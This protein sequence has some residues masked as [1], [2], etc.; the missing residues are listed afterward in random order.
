M[1]ASTKTQPPSSLDHIME[2]YYTFV[3][4]ANP[5]FDEIAMMAMLVNLR[6]DNHDNRAIFDEIALAFPAIGCPRTVYDKVYMQCNN[7]VAEAEKSGKKKKISAAH[8][9]NDAK[10]EYTNKLR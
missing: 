7:G 8:M 6:R 4:L 10:V 1:P 2:I 5:E 3:R 9:T